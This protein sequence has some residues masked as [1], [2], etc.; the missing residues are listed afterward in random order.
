MIAV[1]NSVSHGASAL[2]GGLTSIEAARR[3]EEVGENTVES[4]APEWWR[5]LLAKFWGP[6][7]WLLEIAILAQIADSAY[8]EAAIIGILLAFNAALGIVQEGRADRVL[9]VLKQRLAPT[10][11]IR[12]EGHWVRITASKIVPG[13]TIMLPIG[14]LIPADATIISGS[15]SIDNSS[16][17]GESMPV[18]IGPAGILYAGGLIRRGAAIATVTATGRRTFFGR[19]AELVRTA[20]ATSAEQRAILAFTSTLAAV[21]AGIGAVLVSYGWYLG[22]PGSSVMSLILTALLATI[23]AAL[24]ATFTLSSALGAQKL[25][26]KGVLLTRLTGLHDA[27]AMDV[28][29]ADKTGTLTQNRME[30]AEIVPLA[31]LGAPRILALAA[32]ASSEQDDDP[33]DLAIRTAAAAAGVPPLRVISFVP[34]D[35]EAK[36]S[37]ARTQESGL[38]RIVVKGALEAVCKAAQ[39]PQEA[40]EVSKAHASLG[41]RVIAVAY[42]PAGSLRVIGLVAISDL[43]RADSAELVATL[44]HLGV[45]TVMVT[46]DAVETAEAIA[47][48]VGIEGQAYHAGALRPAQTIEDFGVFA[49]VLPEVKFNLVRSLQRASH[50]VGMCGDGVNDAPALRQAQVGIAVSTA[51]DVAKSAAG[52]VLMEQGLGGIVSA[53]EEGR[54]AHQRLTTYALNMMTKKI[55]IVLFLAAGLVLTGR[56]IMTPAMMVVM[57]LTNDLLAMSLTA[58]RASVSAKPTRWNMRQMS[59]VAF[60]LGA[61]KLAFSISLIAFARYYLDLDQDRLQTFAFVALLFGSQPLIYVLRERGYFWS[62]TPTRWVFA[63]SLADIAIVVVLAVTGSFMAQLSWHL[64]TGIA[65]AT[66]VLAFALDAVKQ[67][68]FWVL[69]RAGTSSSPA[70]VSA[71]ATSPPAP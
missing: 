27:A 61:S 55:E 4:P 47:R 14:S 52:M 49:R 54:T 25:A 2:P 16:L 3:L 63:S 29:C 35:P 8:A 9:A 53:I 38:E 22:L 66:I 28:L 20:K 42:G 21:N 17:T 19:A 71:P 15:A 31:E 67:L 70:V 37:E 18:E 39:A 23:P 51:T 58:D 44:R 11:L 32:A 56:P 34:F 59:L 46:G 5:R 50:V 12:R 60:C 62:S 43:P 45:R 68:A 41:K 7:P 30:V 33:I 48:Q 64:V 65:V 40:I 13:D 10:A 36:T 6:V 57:L 69:D 24:P 1:D 26:R